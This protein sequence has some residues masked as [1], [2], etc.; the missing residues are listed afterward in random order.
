MSEP[1]SSEG[2]GDASVTFRHTLDETAFDTMSDELQDDALIQ[3]KAAFSKFIDNA[4][5]TGTESA[6][7]DDALVSMRCLAAPS[8]ALWL[9]VS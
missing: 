4:I 5:A 3:L 9:T 1:P 7:W 8:H 2:G 6:V